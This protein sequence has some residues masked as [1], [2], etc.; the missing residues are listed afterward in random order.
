MVTEI[1]G[2]NGVWQ[3]ILCPKI[4]Q[5]LFC[6]LTRADK[7]HAGLCGYGVMKR[8][9]Q[10]SD[11]PLFQDLQSLHLSEGATPWGSLIPSVKLLVAPKLQRKTCSWKV[12][13]IWKVHCHCQ[14]VYKGSHWTF[15]WK[16][17]CHCKARFGEAGQR[18]VVSGGGIVLVLL[19]ETWRRC[20]TTTRDHYNSPRT[21]L[22]ERKAR[23]TLNP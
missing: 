15:W 13:L 19:L 18:L 2:S 21:L 3:V 10:I 1:T 23:L 11:Q 12:A 5:I 7:S 9:T 16:C 22:L 17:N 4:C 20:S 6:W 8:A 14:C